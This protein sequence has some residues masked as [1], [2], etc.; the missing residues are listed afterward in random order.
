MNVGVGNEAAKFHFWEC[1][2]RI[3]G[4][5]KNAFYYAERCS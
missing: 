2:N 3:F 5:V 1:I 4:T